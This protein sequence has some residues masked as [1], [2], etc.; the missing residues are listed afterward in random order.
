MAVDYD[1]VQMRIKRVPTWAKLTELKVKKQL[2]QKREVSYD[3][4]I[5]SLLEEHRQKQEAS[6]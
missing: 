1:T 3:D 2:A 5:A 6:A 4:V